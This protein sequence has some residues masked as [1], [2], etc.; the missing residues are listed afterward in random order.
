MIINVSYD[1][2]VSSLPAGFTSGVS[3]VVQ[4]FQS[5]FTDPITFNL[6]VGYGDVHGSPLN[7]GSLGQSYVFLNPYTY[8]QLK[9][10]LLAQATSTDDQIAIGTLPATDPTGG[11][12]I[13]IAQA[14]A[15]ALGL[16]A[17]NTTIDTYVGFQQHRV[18][19]L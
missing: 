2:S 11:G 1:Q 9:T 4:F 14:E 17:P 5:Q 10:A 15:A 12:Q 19:C 8:T 16:L 13:L 18:I 6:H 7:P 3:A